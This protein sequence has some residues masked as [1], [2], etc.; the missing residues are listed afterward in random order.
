MINVLKKFEIENFRVFKEFEMNECK[1]VNLITGPNNI[2]KT[3]LLEA[4]WIHIA[5]SS[6]D[7]IPRTNIF[8]T[9]TG[10]NMN[11]LFYEIFNDFDYNKIITFRSQFDTGEERIHTI[12]SVKNPIIKSDVAVAFKSTSEGITPHL[13]TTDFYNLEIKFKSTI[14]NKIRFDDSSLLYLT[15]QNTLDFKKMDVK[16][17]EAIFLFSTYNSSLDAIPRFSEMIRTKNEEPVLKYMQIIEPKIIKISIGILCQNS[18]I[19]GDI[20]LKELIPLPLLGEGLYKLFGIIVSI[21]NAKDGTLLIDELENGFYY[22]HLPEIWKAIIEFSELMHVQVFI[23]THSKECLEAEYETFKKL[24]K[25]NELMVFN[26]YKEENLIKSTNYPMESFE[27]LLQMGM[28][29]R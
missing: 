17:P 7:T 28:D 12:G 9:F 16:L 20:G 22:K 27:T 8:R 19:Y 18:I 11:R 2:G 6:P 29:V 25:E 15:P 1:K 3:A 24:G 13:I 21:A 26:L 14:G 5:P 23:T 4:L 10:I